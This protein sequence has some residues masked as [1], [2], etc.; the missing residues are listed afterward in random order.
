MKLA[1]GAAAWWGPPKKFDEPE[2]DRRVSWLELFYDL[3]YVIAISRITHHF[4][5]HISVPGFLEYASMF[6]LIF[7]GWVNG[8]L[9]HDI[10]G[11]QGLRTRLMTLWQ[12]M[13]IAALAVMIDQ[14]PEKR[15]YYITIVFMIMQLY[16]TY[17]WWAVG[18]YDPSHR[19][20]NRPY[21][22]LYLTSLA[23]MG[24]SLFLPMTWLKLVVPVV[25]VCNYLP[26]FISNIILR[27]SSREFGLTSS[28]F[29]R[30]GLFGIIIFGEVVL[31]VVNG[32]SGLQVLDLDVWIN[33][34]LAIA[35]VFVMWWLFFTLVSGRE[36]KNGFLNASLLELT[37]IPALM[38]LGMIA[39]SFTIFF[40]PHTGI[41]VQNVLGY[42]IT[43]FLFSISLMMGL[44]RF[45]ENYESLRRPIRIS[46]FFTGI[47]FLLLTLIDLHLNKM[48]YLI[49]TITILVVEI[50]YV[51][52]LY[53]GRVAG[54]H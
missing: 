18:F 44:L 1:K 45:P 24:L 37:Y 54:G 27:R 36:A 13:I 47:V 6:I 42:S 34:A 19:K 3:V 22:I 38:A 8:S 52:S 17:M 48:Y 10:H 7:W 43:I 21:T 12:M 49:G 32:I 33:F 9:Y 23:F 15:Y 11:S 35:I 39:V 41:P 16:I 40:M 31:G 2:Y 46:V 25:L 51:N 30:L 20:Y 4:A 53:Y 5:L 29:E 14:P 28:M 50:I 26:P